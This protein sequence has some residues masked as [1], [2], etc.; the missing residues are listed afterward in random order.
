MD[1]KHPLVP[2]KMP[3]SEDRGIIKRSIP[4]EENSNVA[5]K[6]SKLK[7]KLSVTFLQIMGHHMQLVDLK[8]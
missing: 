8:T 3:R 4:N 1:L 2:E 6:W 7:V 5:M